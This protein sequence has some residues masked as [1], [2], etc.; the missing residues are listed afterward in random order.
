MHYIVRKEAPMGELVSLRDVR[1]QNPAPLEI[2][3]VVTNRL[4]AI[5]TP[6]T[7]SRRAP[8][9]VV[10]YLPCGD[11]EDGT[12][13]E[14][15]LVF[16]AKDSEIFRPSKAKTLKCSIFLGVKSEVPMGA[17][18]N[19]RDEHV[20][21]F[22]ISNKGVEW[23]REFTPITLV[24]APERAEEVVWEIES[25]IDQYHAAVIELSKP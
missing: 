22:R 20:V 2:I 6:N 24:S 8:N 4:Q 16:Q 7:V 18:P 15:E 13:S 11:F 21:G 14:Y 17:I 3:N 23:Y 12:Y 5:A 19:T 1:G 9:E 10:L 25:W